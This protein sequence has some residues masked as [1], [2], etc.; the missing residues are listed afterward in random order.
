MDRIETL[1]G[2]HGVIFG[3]DAVGGIVNLL[4]AKQYYSDQKNIQRVEILGRVSSAEN[5]WST[6]ISG[7]FFFSRWF[8]E[9][10]HM[11]R[12]FGD[13]HGGRKVGRQKNTGYDTRG[14]RFGFLES[15]RIR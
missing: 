8:A 9:I 6:G 1:R 14:T 5:S 11:E 2:T 12:S 3:A 7:E 10:S 13:L 4:S 15:S